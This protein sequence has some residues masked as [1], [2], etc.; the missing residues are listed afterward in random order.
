MSAKVVIGKEET[1][2]NIGLLK[3]SD[4]CIVQKNKNIISY[5]GFILNKNT[6]FNIIIKY[7]FHLSR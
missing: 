1:L 6:A 5:L 3:R 2:Q 4:L 7:A